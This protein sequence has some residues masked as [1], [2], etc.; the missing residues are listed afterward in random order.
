[1]ALSAEGLDIRALTHDPVTPI[2]S[3]LLYTDVLTRI[4]DASL[5]KLGA[6]LDER[7]W[8]LKVDVEHCRAVGWAVGEADGLPE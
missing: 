7:V 3:A 1:L 2:S 5:S 8:V 6:L 4:A